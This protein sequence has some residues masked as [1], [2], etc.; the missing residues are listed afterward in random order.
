MYIQTIGEVSF[1]APTIG[2]EMRMLPPYSIIKTRFAKVYASWS[3]FQMRREMTNLTKNRSHQ[4]S[5]SDMRDSTLSF[6]QSMQL[7]REPKC[8][9]IYSPS[10]TEPVLYA[11]VYAVLTRHLY[12][13][14]ESLSSA[15]RQRWIDY[16]S[17]Y[18]ADD[19]LFKDPM[20]ENEIA[21]IED[22]WGW[23]HLTLH[24]IMALTAL[25]GVVHRPFIFLEPFLDTNYLISW[26]ESR[27][28]KNKPDFVSNEVQN[29]GTLLQYARD[30]HDNKRAGQAVVSLLD[31]L[32]KTQDPQ[33]GLWGKPFN[34][35]LLLSRGVQ[36]GYH[37]WLLFSYDGRP[38]RYRERIIDSALATQNRLGGFG[39]VPN[40]SACEDIDSIDPLVRL[41]F[42]SA[43]RN[44]EIKTVLS[45]ALSWVLANRNDDGG[46][47]F[48]RREPFVYGHQ[49]MSSRRDESAMFP[50]WF[51]TLSLAYLAQALPESA[52]GK[53]DWQFINCPGMQ[54]WTKV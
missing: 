42:M 36:T 40:S 11:S 28:W 43:Y 53:F 50:T 6:V 14:L 19:G 39:V 5:V 22:W 45:R 41:S 54:F 12:H 35:P 10:Q 37:L 16:I 51:R 21:A 1:L 13:D 31:W 30:F 32:E 17:S 25:G 18:Q 52:V 38:I 26:L 2:N 8:Q 27:D 4:L 49:R 34:T 3:S 20:L 47:V 7:N 44:D 24:V 48:R 33:T 29:I 46:F 15:E 9:Y 23:R